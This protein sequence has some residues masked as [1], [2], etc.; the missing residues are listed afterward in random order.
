MF[1]VLCLQNR[2]TSKSF[3]PSQVK[4]GRIYSVRD[5]GAG[6][7]H[8]HGIYHSWPRYLFKVIAGDDDLLSVVK[9]Y[10]TKKKVR[11]LP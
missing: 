3:Y 8:F 1:Y 6:S 9:L 2:K 7:G 4:H 11:A 10:N 5:E